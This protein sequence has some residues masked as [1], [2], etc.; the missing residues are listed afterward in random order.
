MKK[1]KPR[2]HFSIEKEISFYFYFFGK[3]QYLLHG[4]S[5][6]LSRARGGEVGVVVEEEGLFVKIERKDHLFFSAGINHE[7]NIPLQFPTAPF[8]Q[9]NRKRNSPTDTFF[10]TEEKVSL[11]SSL[12]ITQSVHFKLTSPDKGFTYPNNLI[13]IIQRRQQ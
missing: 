10:L 4:L 7:P 9:E 12:R 1:F 6:C 11:S 3:G 5:G 2:L 8:I 13:S